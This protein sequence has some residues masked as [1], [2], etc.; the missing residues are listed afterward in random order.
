MPVI[1]IVG[2][3]AVGKSFLV[4][5]LAAATCSPAFFEGEEGTIPEKIFENVI[6]KGSP[7]ERWKFFIE[8]YKKNLER[9]LEISKNNIDCFVDGGIISA[10]AIISY[11][12][13]KYKKKLEKMI[14]SIEH[15]KSDIIV[16]IIASKEKILDN[17]RK[18]SRALEPDNAV[19]DRALKIQESF[20]A[21]AKNEEFCTV[22]DRTELDFTNPKH[23]NSILEGIN[24]L[25][26]KFAHA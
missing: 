19:I 26:K 10:R 13:N 21:L 3:S 11:E 9:A 7:A 16:L 25:K 8:R 17:L 23:I 22:I 4:K 18:R 1:S 15:L 14:S 24:E 5:Q 20:M 6:K 2:T 12:D